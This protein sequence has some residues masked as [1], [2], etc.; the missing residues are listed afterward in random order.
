M[1]V[2]WLQLVAISLLSAQC[3]SNRCFLIFLLWQN[4]HASNTSDKSDSK[5][6]TYYS[7]GPSKHWWVLFRRWQLETWGS[8]SARVKSELKLNQNRILKRWGL[9]HRGGTLWSPQSKGSSLNLIRRPSPQPA[10]SL[11]ATWSW[12]SDQ[13]L[14]ELLVVYFLLQSQMARFVVVVSRT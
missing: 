3:K 14:R 13:N 8:N 1:G 2:L 12:R 7:K 11:T 6:L 9:L 10:S 4:T 5:Y